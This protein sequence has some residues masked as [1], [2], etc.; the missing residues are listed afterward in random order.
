MKRKYKAKS[1]N[2]REIARERIEI[3][4]KQ[5]K[6]KFSKN[7]KLS[8][9]YVKLARGLAMKVKVRIPPDLKR[10]FCKHCYSYLVPSKNLRVRTHNTKVIYYC[11][12]CKKYMRFPYKK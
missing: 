12:E 8:N 2:K 1:E 11:F 5:A 7:P 3:L 10:K 9:R 4:F 6:E